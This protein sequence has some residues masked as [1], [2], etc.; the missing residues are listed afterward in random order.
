M[1]AAPERAG[2]RRVW[3][4]S[5]LYYPELT[6]TGYFLTRIAEGLAADYEVRAL[7]GQPTHSARGTRAPAR[8][9]RNKVEVV[10]APGTTLDKDRP[11]GRLLNMATVSIAMFVHLCAHLRR[12][13]A[14]LVV[15]TPPPLPFLTAAACALRGARAV[16]LVHDVYP[17]TLVAAGM[18]A[19]DGLPAR[20]LSWLTGRMYGRMTRICALGRDMRTLIL[21]KMPRRRHPPVDIL[22]NWAA[23]EVLTPM[24]RA[25]NPLLAELGL[26]DRFVVQYAGNMGPLHAIEDLVEAA[27]RLAGQAPDVHFLFIGSGGKR[28]WLEATVARE[29]LPNVT[30]LAPR[31][32][33]DQQVFL[34]A[35]DIAITAFV[36]GMFGAGV[37]SRLYNILASGKPIVAAVDPQSELA[38]VVKEERVGWIARPGDVDGIVAAVL[39]A[40]Q[41]RE[42]LAEMGARGRA[43]AAGRYSYA[44]VMSGYRAL[45]ASLLAADRAAE[46]EWTTAGQS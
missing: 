39:E 23:E 32:R 30:V 46:P 25:T 12:G 22:T 45:F 36:P 5:E 2:A 38:L 7:C 19:A 27:R 26:T 34:N 35:C 13:D 33:S 31:P 18:I 40:R 24:P 21:G 44:S 17:E 41:D 16:L 15:T 3:V 29:A 43:A 11:I 28:R 14:V 42:R 37:P 10:R 4:V 8:E 20:A 9:R 6:S 1:T